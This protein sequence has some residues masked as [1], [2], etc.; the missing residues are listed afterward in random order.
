MVSERHL[1]RSGLFN[2]VRSDWSAIPAVCLAFSVGD[3][4]DLIMV[5]QQA[6]RHVDASF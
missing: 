1:R 4:G 5:R 2:S 3:P 6:E